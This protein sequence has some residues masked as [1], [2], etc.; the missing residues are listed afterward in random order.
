MEYRVKYNQ[1]PRVA[2]AVLNQQLSLLR[3]LIF[4]EKKREWFSLSWTSEGTGRV[5]Q[6]ITDEVGEDGN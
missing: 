2:N 4:L 6:Q 5:P 3:Y 1:L